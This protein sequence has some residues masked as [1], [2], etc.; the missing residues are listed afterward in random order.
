MYVPHSL[1]LTSHVHSHTPHTDPHM[2]PQPDTSMLPPHTR[3][4]SPPILTH[5]HL[6]HPTLTSKSTLLSPCTQF[7]TDTQRFPVEDSLPHDYVDDSLWYLLP[8]DREYME[9]YEAVRH[10]DLES[11]RSAVEQEAVA[12]DLR[13]KYNKTPLMVAVAH[14]RV[15]VVEYLVEKG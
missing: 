4:Q 7:F 12:V 8:P 14:G 5:T 2:L 9:L 15:D 10:S 11:L 3:H 13:D 6:P 1:V